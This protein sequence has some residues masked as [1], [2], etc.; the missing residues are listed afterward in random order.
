MHEVL[1]S[2]GQATV[3]CTD[4]GHVHTTRLTTE[5]SVTVNVVVSQEG[6]SLPAT[7]TRSA[8]TT[9][10]TGDEFIVETESGVFT[11]EVTSIE[12][13]G[14]QR[15]ETA[16]TTEIQTLWTRAVGNVA[17]PITVHP[18]AGTGDRHETYSTDVYVPG[19][20]RLTV[21][22][23]ITIDETPI[24]IEGLYLRDEAADAAVS[25]LESPGD[26]AQA[27]D[28]KRVYARDQTTD[29]WSAW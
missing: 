25:P 14:D 8:Q 19:D 28:L 26:Q 6:E 2:G 5:Q 12:L 4:C 29:A 17:V 11:V 7:I 16:P 13:P 24:E 27:K 9:V 22:E 20:R 10:E 18:T 3:K 21:G 1:S 23:E 15:V